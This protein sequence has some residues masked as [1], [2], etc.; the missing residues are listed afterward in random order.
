MMTESNRPSAVRFDGSGWQS[1]YRLLRIDGYE[2]RVVQNPTLSLDGDV[3]AARLGID[4]QDGPVVP[5]GRSYR[6]AVITEAGNDPNVAALVYIAAFAPDA[7]E[8]VNSLTANPP[9][10]A[11]V[12]PRDGF[13]LLDRDKFHASPAAEVPADV[14]EFAAD[15]QAAAGFDALGGTISEPGLAREAELVPPHDG[16]RDDPTSRAANDG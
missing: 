6:G 3:G 2:V 8:S 12:P 15:S 16:G 9:L 11:R 1:V 5:V 10:D 7:G 14:A 4:E 13:L